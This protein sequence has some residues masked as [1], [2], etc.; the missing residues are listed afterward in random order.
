MEVVVVHP[1]IAV[2]CDT[3]LIT[4][5]V[6]SALAGFLVLSDVLGYLCPA[7]RVQDSSL[8]LVVVALIAILGD[9]SQSRETLA[10]RGTG[11]RA[12]GPGLRY[13]EWDIGKAGVL[14]GFQEIVGWNDV[15]EVG[16]R[17]PTRVWDV[18]V[19]LA[20]QGER[21]AGVQ[22]VQVLFAELTF[23][24][25]RI[26][27]DHAHAGAVAIGDHCTAWCIARRQEQPGVRLCTLRQCER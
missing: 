20:K 16:F 2:N 11:K 21:L 3:I 4:R 1:L 6:K 27:H 18:S 23:Q 14:Y 8:I 15:F 22:R 25:G 9:A 17:R 12:R 7:I 19:H 13:V 10:I 5:L 24:V 26:L